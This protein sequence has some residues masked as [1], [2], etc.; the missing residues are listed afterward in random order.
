MNKTTK[1]TIA[2]GAAVLLLLGTGGTLA[3]WN[4][5]AD[6][7]GQTISAGQLT[8]VQDG[9]PTWT[10]QHV[11]GTASDVT[12][13]TG[14][15]IVPGDKLVYQGEYDIT[16]QGQNLAF[17]VG[18]TDSAIAPS[19]SS[20]DTDKALANLLADSAEFSVDAEPAVDAGTP[21]TVAKT[22]ANG[23]VNHTATITATINWPFGDTTTG[24][25]AAQLGSV[26]L[27]KFT[28][29]VTQVDAN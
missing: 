7:G 11:D 24:D 9:T 13:I 6:L 3:Y 29:A 28:L 22:G 8:V 15:R 25:N 21:V 14:L 26:D 16:G 4:G 2:A 20:K 23:I 19:D 5:S 18:L 1:G 12:S 27:S 17:T 10:I